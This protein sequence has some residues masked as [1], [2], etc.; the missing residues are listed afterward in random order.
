M[1]ELPDDALLTTSELAAW[2]H[3]GKG[4]I[5]SLRSRGEMAPSFKFGRIVYT[6]RSAAQEWLLGLGGTPSIPADPQSGVA[7]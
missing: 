3:V 2:L 1:I 5:S 6:R 7:L 4:Q